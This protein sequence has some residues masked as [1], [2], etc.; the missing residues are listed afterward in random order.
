[1]TNILIGLFLGILLG[2]AIPPFYKWIVG[3]VTN[4]K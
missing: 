1:M 3:I 4:K 2:L